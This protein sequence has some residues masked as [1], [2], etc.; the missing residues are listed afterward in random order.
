MDL[1][2]TIQPIATAQLLDYLENQVQQV[3]LL[4]CNR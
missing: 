2:S 4:A 3:A 1:S